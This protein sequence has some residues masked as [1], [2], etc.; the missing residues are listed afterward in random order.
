MRGPASK[1]WTRV[2]K[3]WNIEATCTPLLPAPTT[4]MDG[5]TAVSLKASLWVLVSSKPGM[6]SRRL[7][8]PVQMMNFSAS[9]PQSALCLDRVR[10]GEPRGADLLVDR[11]AERIDTLAQGRARAHVVDDLAHPRQQ[12][13]VPQ[14][15][16]ARG[17]A[18]A[19]Q[20]MRLPHQ[21]RGIGQRPHRH[22]PVV[23]GH[24]AELRA[25]HER[26]PGTQVRRADGGEHARWSR[27]DHDDVGHQRSR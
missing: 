5:G 10:V 22:G 6:A 20:V 7:T 8:P 19:R 2:P 27:A 9:Q 21:P 15:G 25:A 24:A 18:V 1:S 3:A 11:H 16:R 26:G 4:S 17:D 14:L 12:P 23:G 13:V